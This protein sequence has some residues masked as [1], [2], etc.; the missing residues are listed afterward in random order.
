MSHWEFLELK[1]GPDVVKYC[2]QPM[3]MQ[4]EAQ[5]R[6][7]KKLMLQKLLVYSR[8]GL[9]DYFI[10]SVIEECE[11]EIKKTLRRTTINR[12]YW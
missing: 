9:G 12:H 8:G 11:E 4:S 3:L 6:R 2:I 10:P 7:N 5:V 1:L